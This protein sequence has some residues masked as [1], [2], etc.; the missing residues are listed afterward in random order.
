M[1]DIQN[2]NRNVVKPLTLLNKTNEIIDAVNEQLN[3][4]YSENNPILTSVEGICTWTINHGLETEEVSCTVYEG[5]DEVSAKVNI[6]S[7]NVVTVTINSSSNIPADTYSVLILAKGG[8]ISSESSIT[9]DS[10]LSS[11]STNPIQNRVITN[12]VQ[13]SLNKFI[14]DG[15]TFTVET[16]G[17]GDFATLTDA[18]NYLNQ[19]WSNGFVSITLGN[20]TF[21][22]DSTLSLDLWHSNIKTIA[23][24]GKGKTNTFIEN[25][26]TQGQHLLYFKNPGFVLIENLTLQ[27]TGGTP[28]TNYRGIT[29]EFNAQGLIKNVAFKGLNICIRSMNNASIRGGGTIDFTDCGE[30]VLSNTSNLTTE[31]HSTWNFNNCNT[32]F[33]AYHGGTIH[34]YET[35]CNYT[36][37]TTKVN[38]AV[39]TPTNDGWIT[40]IPT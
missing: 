36:S 22:V 1:P 29:Y 38:P 30:C 8:L 5:D 25:N 2:L 28:S 4:S 13:P 6:T 40:G 32:A 12:Y 39:G 34:G 26:V 3:T 20:G 9:V 35:I 7:E 33:R 10:E 31:Y 16:D 24:Y 19:K 17:S 14:P 37:V 18:F 15:T 23:I 27:H 21:T 11:S